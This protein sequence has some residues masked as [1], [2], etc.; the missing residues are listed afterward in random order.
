MESIG[1]IDVRQRGNK[2][3]IRKELEEGMSNLSANKQHPTTTCPPYLIF[4]S[5]S[6]ACDSL[7][8]TCPLSLVWGQALACSLYLA[9]GHAS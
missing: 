7:P 5:P 6:S 1:R 4:S 3:Q 8:L 2:G 9:D